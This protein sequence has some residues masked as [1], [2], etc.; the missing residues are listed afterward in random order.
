M[1]KHPTVLVAGRRLSEEEAGLLVVGLTYLIRQ[2]TDADADAAS[3]LMEKLLAKPEAKGP[4]MKKVRN[5]MSG[6]EIEIA[7][8]TPLCLDPSSETYWSM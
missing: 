6:K 3:K 1:M 5:L 2:G 7:E 4:K 8:D